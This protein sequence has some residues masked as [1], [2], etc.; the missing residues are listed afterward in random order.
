MGPPKSS[1]E[2]RRAPLNCLINDDSKL[3]VC[4]LTGAERIGDNKALSECMP[5]KRLRIRGSSR[6]TPSKLV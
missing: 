2:K 3:M 6:I 4:H 5:K 1:T